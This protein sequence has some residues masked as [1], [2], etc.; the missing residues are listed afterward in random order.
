VLFWKFQVLN[1]DWLIGNTDRSLS[2][3]FSTGSGKW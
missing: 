3:R 1:V 2:W